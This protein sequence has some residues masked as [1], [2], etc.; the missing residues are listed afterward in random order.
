MLRELRPFN[1]RSTMFRS[2][3]IGWLLLFSLLWVMLVD[4]NRFY[5]LFL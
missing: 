4:K 3:D 2:P 1:E 5:S